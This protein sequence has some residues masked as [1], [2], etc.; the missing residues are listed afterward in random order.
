[1]A[2]KQPWEESV[3]PSRF[4]DL[5][6]SQALEHEQKATTAVP[7]TEEILNYR[8]KLLEEAGKER[9][10]IVCDLQEARGTQD[11]IAYDEHQV[12]ALAFAFDPAFAILRANYL[13]EVLAEIEQVDDQGKPLSPEPIQVA[14]K[15]TPAIHRNV[16]NISATPSLLKKLKTTSELP[17]IRII[18]VFV[19]SGQ[20]NLDNL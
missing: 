3:L 1:M 2:E 19:E 17:R 7:L 10:C 5:S 16:D 6:I 18:D 4:L 12:Q 20:V 13:G 14:L 11:I 9:V 8:K 15:R